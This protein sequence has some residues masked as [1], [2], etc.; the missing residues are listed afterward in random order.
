MTRNTPNTSNST[1]GQRPPLD[2]DA[3]T[4]AIPRMGDELDGGDENERS[5]DVGKDKRGA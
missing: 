4:V 2:P 1:P 3:D 5:K